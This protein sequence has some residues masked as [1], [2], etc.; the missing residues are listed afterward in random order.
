MKPKQ[1]LVLLSVPFACYLVFSLSLVSA[2]QIGE[3]QNTKVKFIIEPVLKIVDDLKPINC[4]SSG[5]I[6]FHAYV[7]NVLE[8][9]IEGIEAFV[10]D[11]SSDE[12]HN[13]TSALSCFPK[14]KLISNQEI[15]CNLHV[16]ELLSE[17]PSCPLEKAENRFYL[18]L[19]IS[20]G[21]KKAKI[22][23]E[24]S[25]IL[26]EPGIEPN[27]EINFRISHPPYPVPEINCKTGSEIDVPVVIKHAETLYGDVTWSFSVNETSYGGNLIECE[28]ILSREGEGMENI[29][30]CNLVVSSTAFPVCERGEVEIG[31]RAKTEDYNLFGNFSTT[32]ISEDLNLGLSIS[33]IEKLECQ[34]IDENG[35]CVPKEPQQNVTA[36]ITGN[37]PAGLR[38]F[39]TRYKLGDSNITITH[40][41][42]I[43]YDK[44][45][46][47]TFITIDQLPVPQSK[48]QRTTKSRTLTLFFDVKYLNYY[49]NISDSTNVT[50]EGVILDELLNTM[51]VLEEDIKYLKWIKDNIYWIEEA[52]GWIN[53]IRTC[54]GFELV[55]KEL[56]KGYEYAYNGLLKKFSEMYLWGPASEWWGKIIGVIAQHGPGIV[57]C[58]AE[59]GIEGINKEMKNLE[60]FEEGEITSEMEIPTIGELIKE[61]IAICA[62]ENFWDR[63]KSTWKL[64]LCLAIRWLLAS[65][66]KYD[67]CTI[68]QNPV[69]EALLNLI[70][71]LVVIISALLLYSTINHGMKSLA[72]AR[73]RINLQIAATNIMTDYLE[74]LK[75]TMETLA[76]NMALNTAFLNLTYP[77]YDTVKLIFISDRTGVLD[78]QDEI[79]VGDSITIEYDFEK[80]NQTEGFVSQ[81]SI[82]PSKRGPLIFDSLKGTYGPYL[83]DTLLGTNPNIDPSEM[84]TFTLSYEDKKLDYE[85][86]YMNHTCI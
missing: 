76:T 46:C 9:D 55:K 53:L 68:L 28:K 39:E 4:G 63:I 60:D 33:G 85:L 17:L 50:L 7:E 21:D 48:D 34:I 41:K 16:R 61:Y 8:F 83:T 2:Y 10:E 26:T 37:V 3:L 42:K 72:L 35:T 25:F 30:L 73:E 49:T 44:Y 15:T 36:R 86:Y 27:L 52:Y 13:V 23:S 58:I 77:I 79:C 24:K 12:T 65:I 69:I 66:L 82:T 40:C 74:K 67:A 70:D 59:K 56:E 75:N 84:Y 43:R 18:T 20:Y 5:Y 6:T 22:S 80:L 38:V 32:T 14:T 11:T 51:N 29:Y 1:A 81:L 71:V 64:L 19:E 45:E 78:N 62:I 47:L 57:R 54:C 31:L